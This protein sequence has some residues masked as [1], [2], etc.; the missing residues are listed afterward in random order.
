MVRSVLARAMMMS[1]TTLIYRA[2]TALEE[3][4]NPTV[5]DL[6]SFMLKGL[7]TETQLVQVLP[8]DLPRVFP[9]M[10]PMSAAEEKKASINEDVGKLKAENDTLQEKL[11]EMEQRA[12]DDERK[13][14]EMMSWLDEMKSQFGS[15]E[16]GEF[17]DKLRS[18]I[19]QQREVCKGESL[20]ERYATH[21]LIHWPPLDYQTTRAL[22]AAKR[23][24]E[25]QH[26][27]IE[28]RAR[29][30]GLPRG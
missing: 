23:R 3:L 22:A 11:R 21:A 16:L 5:K 24:H 29:K 4:G 30:V 18:M 1:S 6:G 26:L 14:N 9:E 20:S 7:T 27:S 15:N 8:A 17:K 2:C 28:P 25:P 13:A 12:L 19:N 10:K